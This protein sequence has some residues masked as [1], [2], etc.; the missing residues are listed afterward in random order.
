MNHPPLSLDFAEE[1]DADIE[2][3]YVPQEVAQRVLVKNCSPTQSWR[4]FLGKTT[5]EIAKKIGISEAEYIQ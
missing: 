1:A 5:D 2:E 3:S 4:E